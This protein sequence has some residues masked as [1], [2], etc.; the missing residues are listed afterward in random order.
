MTID[1]IAKELGVAT[2]TVSRA[3]SGKGRI[4]KE[5]QKRILRYIEENDLDLNT[6]NQNLT[7]LKTYNI[8]VAIP[9]FSDARNLPFFQRCLLGVCEAAQAMDYDVLVASIDNDSIKAVERLVENKK[10]DGMILTRALVNDMTVTYLKSRN[11]PFVLIGS[12]DDED[13]YQVDSDNR[14]GCRELTS[15]LGMIGMKRIGL[16]GGNSNH[17]VTLDRYSGY[18][19]GL[20][21][22]GIMFDKELVCLDAINNITIKQAVKRLAR[23]G[24]DCLACM[25]DYICNRALKELMSLDEGQYR[26]IT[27]ASFYETGE[28]ALGN[29]V[30]SLRY[31]P[32]EIGIQAARMLFKIIGKKEV[33]KTKRL[34]YEVIMRKPGA[35]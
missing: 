11:V 18:E 27:L 12:I 34:G 4:G 15:Y 5:T 3:I 32:N 35:K 13:I 30:Y 6:K 24:I 28:E 25:D 29:N 2:S 8:G 23:K 19:E 21:A 10:M 26:G 17:K 9:A 1:M 14:T 16:I 22:A 33:N 20:K 31:D 7:Q